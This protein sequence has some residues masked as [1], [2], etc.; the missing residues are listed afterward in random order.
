[1]ASTVKTVDAIF[2]HRLLS[3]MASTVLNG[4]HLQKGNVH[5]GHIG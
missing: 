4:D 5:R 1:M 3:G 2:T